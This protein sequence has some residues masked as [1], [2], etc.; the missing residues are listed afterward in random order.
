MAFAFELHNA[1]GFADNGQA[2]NMPRI[3]SVS[4]RHRAFTLVEL[5]TVLAIIAVLTAIL[6][7]AV[8][9]VL[10]NAR[11]TQ[12]GA[13]LR[14]IAIAYATYVNETGT[15]RTVTATTIYDWALTL[16]KS[17]GIDD[18][19]LYYFNDDPLVTESTK[20][21]PKSVAF[22]DGK[23]N[24]TLNSDFEGFPLSVAVVSG[25]STD[26]NP[27]TTPVAWTRGLQADGTWKG[28]SDAMPSA[29]NG[30]GGYI[31]FLDGHVQWYP[32]LKGDDGKGALVNYVT[33]QPTYNVKD[34]LNSTATVLETN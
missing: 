26:A 21:H 18:A 4:R 28:P 16:A 34:A 10:H 13:N 32:T 9:K 8:S 33:K 2:V 20:S 17:G 6:I 30:E 5:L 1:A 29:W 7:P 19:D 22:N 3:L 24:W 31:A 12:S 27:S 14:Q 25:L 23:G 11:R 15:P